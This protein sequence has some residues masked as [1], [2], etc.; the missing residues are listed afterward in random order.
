MQQGYFR[1]CLW[2][3]QVLE[4]AIRQAGMPVPPNDTATDP[5]LSVQH[6]Q[7]GMPV[8]SFSIGY[9]GNGSLLPGSGD[10]GG[11]EQWRGGRQ[12]LGGEVDVS[13]IWAEV[14][15]VCADVGGAGVGRWLQERQASSDRS[16]VSDGSDNDG[17]T[18]LDVGALAHGAMGALATVSKGALADDAVGALA[19]GA[20]GA[21]ADG[22][23]SLFSG[24][25][26]IHGMDLVA[27]GHLKGG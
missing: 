15:L 21:L 4:A 19:H 11:G 5:Q 27:N 25:H 8:K 26:A 12:L 3:I 16:S 24:Q 7:P 13:R 20:M 22:A 14:G 9:Q 10:S 17:D 18:D 2:R 1:S 23:S 6:E